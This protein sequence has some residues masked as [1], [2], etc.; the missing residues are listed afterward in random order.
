MSSSLIVALKNSQVD[1]EVSLPL[2]IREQ[3]QSE[4]KT[5]IEQGG[6]VSGMLCSHGFN[7]D[8]LSLPQLYQLPSVTGKRKR[9]DDESIDAPVAGDIPSTSVSRPRKRLR[10]VVDVA[11]AGALGALGAWLGLAFL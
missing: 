7:F 8:R 5:L 1:A 11:T 6:E 9:G 4:V 2:R 10:M 3:V